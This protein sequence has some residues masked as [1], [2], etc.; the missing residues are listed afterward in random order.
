MK[1]S[2]GSR[3]SVCATHVWVVG[4]YDAEGKPNMMTVAWGGVCCS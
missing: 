3:I 1:R 4:T 2:L